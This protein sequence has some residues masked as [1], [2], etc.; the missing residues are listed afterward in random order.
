[1]RQ[2]HRHEYP[3]L[4]GTVGVPIANKARLAPL[5]LAETVNLFS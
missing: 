1:M 5:D 3:D 2:D 4:G